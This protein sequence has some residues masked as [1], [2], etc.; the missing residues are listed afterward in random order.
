M[1]HAALIGTFADWLRRS[2]EE[3]IFLVGDHTYVFSRYSALLLSRVAFFSIAK[4]FY[5]FWR[6]IFTRNSA[7]NLSNYHCQMLP[8]MSPFVSLF[9]SL[10]YV[11]LYVSVLSV[12]H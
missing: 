12:K 6:P 3:K 10:P 8:K 4:F 7:A 11:S 2:H 5:K 1:Y 9:S